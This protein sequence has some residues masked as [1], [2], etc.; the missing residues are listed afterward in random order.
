M[1]RVYVPGGGFADRCVTAMAWAPVPCVISAQ[2]GVGG[3]RQWL[4]DRPD[5]TGRNSRFL[6]Y[7][8]S[9]PGLHYGF[10]A[11]PPHPSGKS[12]IVPSAQFLGGVRQVAMAFKLPPWRDD[13]LTRNDFGG[14]VVQVP[15]RP[16][17]TH[18]RIKF[19]YNLALECTA[20]SEA[21]VTDENER[22]FAFE[23]ETNLAPESCSNGCEI[24][25]PAM[26]GRLLYYRAEW[27]TG[28]HVVGSGETAAVA[29]P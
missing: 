14:L 3:V 23:G 4:I 21:C 29:M 5:P 9:A 25:V 1:P 6:T 17:A 11:S 26:S 12:V 20:R 19:G 8:W 13:T 16:G 7:G 2:P 27:L 24:P 22:P 18:A 15:G 28:G 10:F